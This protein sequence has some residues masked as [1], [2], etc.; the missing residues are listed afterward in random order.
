MRVISRH[1]RASVRMARAKYV[2]GPGRAEVALRWT[3]AQPGAPE[4][5][6]VFDWVTSLPD[7]I[8]CCPVERGLGRICGRKEK[9]G[10]FPSTEGR[11][12]GRNAEVAV[13]LLPK[14]TSG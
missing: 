1:H 12:C 14:G 2:Q 11:S 6:K 13:I 7:A 8:S 4:E 3:A 10:K 5:N 9:A